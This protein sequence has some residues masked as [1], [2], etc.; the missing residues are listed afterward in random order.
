VRYT[1]FLLFLMGIIWVSK[2]IYFVFLIFEKVGCNKQT[3]TH[4]SH[5]DRYSNLLQD[6]PVDL[7]NLSTLTAIHHKLV[8]TVPWENLSVYYKEDRTEVGEPSNVSIDPDQLFDK[9][10][11][12][13][14]G[15]CI[16]LN[17][18]LSEI[19]KDC[20]FVV[21]TYSAKVL[22]G[23][24]DDETDVIIGNR[25]DNHTVLLVNV[26]NT[27]Y[28]CDIGFGEDTSLYPILLA[29]N[30]ISSGAG[31]RDIKFGKGNWFGK[32]G[33]MLRVW[34]KHKI[35]DLVSYKIK[36]FFEDHQS[37]DHQY[38]QKMLDTVST[39]STC[40]PILF[41]CYCTLAYSDG[42]RISLL[43]NDET[44]YSYYMRD[45]DGQTLEMNK[46]EAEDDF[47]RVLK[48]KFEITLGERK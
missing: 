44:G 43:G 28:V 7:L 21:E 33:Y 35:P 31:G 5:S 42:R 37:F 29:D 26:D 11:K 38:F 10:S 3:M 16:E 40:P 13:R 24:R 22:S 47:R 1:L 15:V 23:I 12:K 41:T 25:L 2:Y 27:R 30:Q 4:R 48:E 6:I 14:G 17:Q 8:T 20:G 45:K 18:L 39:P 46:Y 34:D 36:Y 32:E 19:L 9:I